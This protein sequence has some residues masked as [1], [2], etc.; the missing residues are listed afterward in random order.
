MSEVLASSTSGWVGSAAH[1]SRSLLPLTGYGWLRGLAAMLQV[2][3]AMILKA[4]TIATS[5]L[6]PAKGQ[7]I[8]F[9]ASQHHP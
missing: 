3:M 1:N 2:V 5:A 6:V 7:R 9:L 4:M 8:L